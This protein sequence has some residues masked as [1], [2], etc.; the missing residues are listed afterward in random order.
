MS[1][2]L[3][4]RDLRFQSI[5]LI[6]SLRYQVNKNRT[7]RMIKQSR[8]HCGGG[9][10]YQWKF[11]NIVKTKIENYFLLKNYD[12]NIR[13]YTKISFKIQPE[14]FFCGNLVLKI[15]LTSLR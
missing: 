8:I 3:E 14:T 11:Q 12:F 2:Q 5:K 1:I 10:E 7:K 15:R 13:K 4:L 6:T 9:G